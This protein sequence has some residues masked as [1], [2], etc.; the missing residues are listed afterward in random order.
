MPV[1]R[2]THSIINTAGFLHCEECGAADFQL[3]EFLCWVF[4]LQNSVT[5]LRK[6]IYVMQIFIDLLERQMK[7]QI[8]GLQLPVELSGSIPQK[9]LASATLDIPG[10]NDDALLSAAARV[11]LALG[12]GTDPAAVLAGLADA[13]R[14]ALALAA[15]YDLPLEAAIAGILT[16]P[17]ARTVATD[18]EAMRKLLDDY[19]AGRIHRA[20]TPPQAIDRALKLS[21]AK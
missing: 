13:T 8:P 20:A 9:M 19:R 18:L 5:K 11:A 14:A 15:W 16:N 7:T 12:E 10:V 6:G 17:A 21:E 1:E 2:S 4:Q 3:D